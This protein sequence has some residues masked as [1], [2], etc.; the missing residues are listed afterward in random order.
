MNVRKHAQAT[1]LTV[2]LMAVDGRHVVRV[3]DEGIGF[4]AAEALRPR[5]GHLG[6]AAMAER[7]RLVGGV[8]RVDSDTHAGTTVDLKS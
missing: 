8:L 6:L 7:L 2:S 1:H 5:T 4:N 3:R